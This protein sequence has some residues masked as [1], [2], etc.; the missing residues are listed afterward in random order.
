MKLSDERAVEKV[1]KDAIKSW[2]YITVIFSD[3]YR[4]TKFFFETTSGI[5]LTLYFEAKETVEKLLKAFF[6]EVKKP[7]L[8]GKDDK[9]NFL[10][11]A[12]KIKYKHKEIIE[13]TFKEFDCRITVIDTSNLLI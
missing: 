7:E 11:N 8:F 9:I 1:P 3:I 13:N 6:N 12:A 10:Y 2:L 5:I 4:F